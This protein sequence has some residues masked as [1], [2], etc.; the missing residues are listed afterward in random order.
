MKKT[1]YSFESMSSFLLRY[2]KIISFSYVRFLKVKFYLCCRAVWLP[3]YYTN[4][5]STNQQIFMKF[6]VAS[7]YNGPCQVLLTQFQNENRVPFTG[8]RR[9]KRGV[10]YPTLSN[11]QV[12]ETVELY[13]YSPLDCHGSEFTLMF[14]PTN[15][16]NVLSF[17]M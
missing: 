4:T 17:C 14:V 8:V 5:F 15:N 9:P 12:K 1:F 16:T 7:D 11:S 2:S 10:D 6:Y 13:L 3:V